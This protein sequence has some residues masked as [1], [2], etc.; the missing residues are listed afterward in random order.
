MWVKMQKE[1]KL[2]SSEIKEESKTGKKKKL[3]P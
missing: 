2:G 1:Q 3:S